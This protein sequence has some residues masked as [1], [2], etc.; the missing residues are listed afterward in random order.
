MGYLIYDSNTQIRFDDRLLAHLEVVI[1]SK[2]RR[3]ESFPLT[4]LEGSAGDARSVL[5]LDSAIPLRIRFE[6]GQIG[7]LDRDWVERM[8]TT[9]AGSSGLVVLDQ[10]GQRG[11]GHT[12]TN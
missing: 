5:W 9:A 12:T 4:W 7:D 10:D 1:L 2:L 6:Q 8:S 3:K 11:R